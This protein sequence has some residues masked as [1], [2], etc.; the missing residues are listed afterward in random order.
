MCLLVIIVFLK[1]AVVLKLKFWDGNLSAGHV[2]GTQLLGD[3]TTAGCIR[4]VGEDEFH[5]C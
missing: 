1:S 2:L 3:G 4:D 5:Q